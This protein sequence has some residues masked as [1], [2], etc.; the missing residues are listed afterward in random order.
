MDAVA[1]GFVLAALIDAVAFGRTTP[2]LLVFE[3]AGAPLLAIF[4]VRRNHPVVPLLVIAAF[5]VIGTTVQSA[6]WPEVGDTGGVW[7]LAL[8]FAAYWIGARAPAR[9]AVLGGAVPLLVGLAVDVPTRSGWQLLNGVVFVAMFVGVLPTA[10]GQVVRIRRS[11]LDELDRQRDDLVRE[12]QAQCEAAVLSERLTTSERL[13]PVLLKGMQKLAEEADMGA[14][15]GRIEDS[16][17]GLLRRTREEVVALTASVDASGPA[18]LPMAEH[19]RPLRAIAQPWS[20]LGGGAIGAGLALESTRTLDLATPA[21]VAL[22]A[23]AIVGVLLAAVSRRPLLAV[24]LAWIAATGFSRLVAPLD[25]T[26]SG[27]ALALM[28]AFSVAALSSRRGAVAGLVLCWCGQLVGVGAGDRIGDALVILICWL[29]GLVVNEAGRLV[30][31][32][33]EN[34]RVLIGR[35][36]AARQRAVVAERLRLARELHDQLGHSLTVVALQAGAARRVNAT[37]PA[38]ARE[39]MATVATAAREGLNAM[40]G[41]GAADWEALVRRTRTAGLDLAVAAVSGET[42]ERL[43]LGERMLVVRV[44]QEALTNVLRHAPGAATSVSV[45]RDEEGVTLVIGNGPPRATRGGAGS[46]RGLLGLR[47]S[48]SARGG[49]I[50]WGSRKDG[51]FEVRAVLPVLIREDVSR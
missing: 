50:R 31:Q 47:E 24:T 23:S 41:E 20:V 35:E 7:M 6:V 49:D 12:Q 32:R 4:A 44:V 38:R 28:A 10:V 21:W 48:V 37:D 25:G 40:R 51:G 17:R 5:A 26:L 3:V 42:I 16:A 8:L 30:E 14:D 11:R 13:W 15:P 39:V 34:N 19:L 2:G 43:D 1:A 29:G 46:R 18:E 27:T 33:R 36:A 45:R 9:L 22:L